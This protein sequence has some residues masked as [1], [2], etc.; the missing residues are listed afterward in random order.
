MISGGGGCGSPAIE[1]ARWK[2]S[3]TKGEVVIGE[4]IDGKRSGTIRTPRTPIYSRDGRHDTEGPRIRLDV[5]AA[6]AIAMDDQSRINS[7]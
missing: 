1:T 3:R 2:E 5:L 4:R 7:S 6:R